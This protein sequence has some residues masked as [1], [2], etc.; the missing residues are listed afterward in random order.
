[1][2]SLCSCK[3]LRSARE[4][5]L[6]PCSLSPLGLF[7]TLIF[8][9]L[10]FFSHKIPHFLFERSVANGNTKL[11]CNRCYSF[12]CSHQENRHFLSVLV[13]SPH[14][15]SSACLPIFHLLNLCVCVQPCASQ[16]FSDDLVRRGMGVIKDQGQRPFP[17]PLEDK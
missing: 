5:E 4:T 2:L 7:P 16:A 8:C 6:F 12:I 1:M 11:T 3:S 14:T 13:C 17:F 10:F 15:F 9:Q